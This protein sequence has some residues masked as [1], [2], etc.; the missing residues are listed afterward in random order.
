M[1]AASMNKLSFIPVS[2]LVLISLINVIS[3]PG[4]ANIIPPQGGY[5]DSIPPLLVKA[6]PADSSKEF[7]ERRITLTFDEFVE[8]QNTR[9]NLVISPIPQ[10]EPVV[11]AKLRTVVV[12]LK[13]SLESNTTYTLNFG[14]AIKDI[15][16]GNVAKN[17][18]Y[19]FSTGNTFDSLTLSG[20]VLLAENGKVDSTLAVILHSHGEDSAVVNQRP[21]YLTRLDSAGNFIFRNLPAGTFY[22]YALKDEAGTHRYFSEKQ[23]FAFT[24]KPVTLQA[25]NEPVILYAYSEKAPPGP[26]LTPQIAIRQRGG[27]SEKRLK[28]QMNLSNGELDLLKN[29]IINFEQPLRTLDTSA[30]H[31]STDSAFIPVTSYQILTDTSRKKLTLQTNWKENTLYHI[32]LEKDFAEDTLGRKLLKTDTISFKTKKLSDYGS[33]RIRFKNLDLSENPVL[34]FVQNDNIIKSVPLTSVE[35]NQPIFPPGQYELRIL[36]DRNKNGKW[37]AGEFFGKHIQPEIVKPVSR[38]ITVKANWDNDFDI[39]L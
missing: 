13:D 6:S 14:N 2:L 36:K 33:V 20:K 31:F 17:F 29:V 28:L 27:G 26:V 5:R 4:C 37:D 38:Q 30:I 1:F 15:N 19:I 10:T 12:R 21:R 24:D 16:E 11:E 25:V 22:L 34:L 23:L 7:K 8:L 9:E 32:I 35:I 39:A 18:T 3:G